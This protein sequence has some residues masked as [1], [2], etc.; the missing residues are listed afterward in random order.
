MDNPS[1]FRFEFYFSIS[2][3]VAYYTILKQNKVP[4][5]IIFPSVPSRFLSLQGGQSAST[6]AMRAGELQDLRKSC[7]KSVGFGSH[8]YTNTYTYI[9]R[10]YVHTYIHTYLSTYLPSYLYTY[11][12]C[13]CI[14]ITLHC[15]TFPYLTLRCVALGSITLYN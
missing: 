7:S 14:C 9:V 1:F 11:L 4:S 15:V 6:A 8:T 12:H 13:N 10:T 3:G 2:S 5:S